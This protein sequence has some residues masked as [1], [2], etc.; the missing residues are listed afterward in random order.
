MFMEPIE[1]NNSEIT[2]KT[3]KIRIARNAIIVLNTI[4]GLLMCFVY[5][6]LFNLTFIILG[7]ALI[8]LNIPLFFTFNKIEKQLKNYL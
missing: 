4:A 6:Q 5:F 7:I 1:K 3:K 8:L 2:S